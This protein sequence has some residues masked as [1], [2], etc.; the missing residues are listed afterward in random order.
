MNNNEKTYVIKKTTTTK[1][2]RKTKIKMRMINFH[3]I[4]S[5]AKNQSW[6]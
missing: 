3:R 6:E 2:Q 1:Q 5:S 4:L